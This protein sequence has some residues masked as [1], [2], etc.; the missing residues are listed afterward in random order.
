VF[1]AH[2][3]PFLVILFAIFYIL[4]HHEV[5]SL[6]QGL[7]EFRRSVLV[8]KQKW[9]EIVLVFFS[10]SIA[11][12]IATVLK[13][14]FHTSRPNVLLSD[15]YPLISK[16]DFSFPSGHATSFMA[17]GVAIFLTHKK[18]GYVFMLLALLIG[19]ARIVA[20]V[21]FPVD[22]LGGFVL[23]VLVAFAVKFFYS[24]S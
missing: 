13:Y 1:V 18:A 16:T 11:W 5:I 19:L 8:L 3:L 21:H 6:Q 14:I 23:G 4:L 10:G 22:I 2:T 7:T 20:G 17:L 15:V 12:V 9:K 24:K